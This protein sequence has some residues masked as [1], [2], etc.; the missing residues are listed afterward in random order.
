MNEENSGITDEDLVDYFDEELICPYCRQKITFDEGYPEREKEDQEWVCE[1][2]GKEFFFDTY[3]TVYFENIR[4]IP[5]R[6]GG[7]H[8]WAKY[9]ENERAELYRCKY[10]NAVKIIGKEVNQ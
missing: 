2:C 10:C 8:R 3:C 9:Y 5:C 7:E 6:N 1:T 4:K